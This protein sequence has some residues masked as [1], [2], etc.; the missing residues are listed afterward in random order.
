M[1]HHA[2]AEKQESR[3]DPH[4][5][6]AQQPWLVFLHSLRLVAS[7]CSS[8]DSGVRV[9][10]AAVLPFLTLRGQGHFSSSTSG[11]LQKW[12]LEVLGEPPRHPAPPW[13]GVGPASCWV[14][15]THQMVPRQPDTDFRPLPRS[16]ICLKDNLWTWHCGALFIFVD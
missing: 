16:L 9:P 5:S 1:F 10:S 11:S 15:G 8:G 14:Y 7:A 2:A 4:S 6:A 13:P 3:G 12:G